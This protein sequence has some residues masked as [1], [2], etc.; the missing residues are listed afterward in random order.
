VTHDNP[1][2]RSGPDTPIAT[3]GL[4]CL[5]DCLRHGLPA[6]CVD[7]S[8]PATCR[9]RLLPDGVRAG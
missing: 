4:A 7:A 2:A 5:A 1:D 9:K 6:E 8:L 3:V